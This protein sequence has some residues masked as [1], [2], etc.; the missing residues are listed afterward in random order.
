MNIELPKLNL[1]F[2]KFKY[3]SH[4]NTTQIFDSFRKKY[5]ALTPEEWV[6]Q[7]FLQY[8]VNEKNFPAGLIRVEMVLRLSAVNK[9]CDAVVYNN[10]SEPVV[11]IECK[12]PTVKLNQESFK[13]ISLYNSVLSVKYLMVS[14]G[15]VHY[16]CKMNYQ[17]KSYEFLTDIPEFD[18][19]K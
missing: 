19:I 15:I 3:Q 2:Y 6:R 14:N 7:N 12:A 16:C 9:R 18:I 8:L 1:P 10:R 11:I 4:G 5:V 13:Q 17:D